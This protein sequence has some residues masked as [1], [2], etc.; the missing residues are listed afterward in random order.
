[1]ANHIVPVA[2]G[3]VLG[4]CSIQYRLEVDPTDQ[5]TEKKQRFPNWEPQTTDIELSWVFLHLYFQRFT[6]ISLDHIGST[7]I[8]TS[9]DQYQWMP[10][11]E[12]MVASCEPLTAACIFT[13]KKWKWQA[14]P[15]IWICTSLPHPIQIIYWRYY[16]LEVSNTSTGWW[17]TYPS[18][19]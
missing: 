19:K 9:D 13:L 3:L 14:N 2:C 15:P 18:E 12:I 4:G 11:T 8:W 17:Y 7:A 1:M 6:G 10:K 16:S 5:M